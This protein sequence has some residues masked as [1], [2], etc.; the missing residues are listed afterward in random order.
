M[1]KISGPRFSSITAYCDQK[2]MGGGWTVIQRRQDGTVDFQ[3]NWH[4]YS[5][6]FGHLDAEFWFGNEN[7]HD[8][9]KRSEAPNNSTLLINMKIRGKT[10]PVY[11]KYSSFNIGDAAS[12]YVLGISGFSGNASNPKFEYHNKRK[13]TTFDQDN[14]A[15]SKNCASVFKGGWWYGACFKVHLNGPYYNIPGFSYDMTW[16]YYAHPRVYPS[17]VEMKI[18]RNL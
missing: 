5:N 2:T 13:F 17:F 6:G 18:K 16:D 7:I 14:D 9:T 1:Y 12:K 3:K 11:G 10:V 4:D 15:Y 8:L